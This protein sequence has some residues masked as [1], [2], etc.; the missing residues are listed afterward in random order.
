MGAP[1]AMALGQIGSSLLGGLTDQSGY[2]KVSNFDKTQKGIYKRLGQQTNQLG[3]QGGG[4]EQAIGILQQYLNPESDVYKNFEAPYRQEF[5]QQTVPGLAERFAGMGAQGGALSSSGFGQA[6]GAAG[7]NLQTNLAQLK[8]GL[9]RQSIGDIINQY[10]KLSG[11]IL[12]A[13]PFSYMDQGPG[14]LSNALSG[15]GGM[16]N[17]FGA[18]NLGGGSSTNAP[19][20]GSISFGPY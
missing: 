7:A 12:S 17:P 15:F 18:P 9:Q 4:Y 6:L 5:E 8:S 2:K 16:K 11:G 14:G 13:Q 10:N 20:S 1:L 19:K 3:Q